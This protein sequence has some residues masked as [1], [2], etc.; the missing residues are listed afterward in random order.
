M[1]GKLLTAT[2]RPSQSIGTLY[3]LPFTVILLR[4]G[5]IISI[6]GSTTATLILGI[7]VVS[8]SSQLTIDPFERYLGIMPGQSVTALAEFDCRYIYTPES[9]KQNRCMISP[10]SNYI[11]SVY[12]ASQEKAII[13]VG[14]GLKSVRVGDLVVLWGRPSR[15]IREARRFIV[16]WNNGATVYIPHKNHDVLNLYWHA[17]S[18][19][20]HMPAS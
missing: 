2:Y 17:M 13:E 15:I 6:I 16:Q 18:V 14:M 1:L 8:N 9:F 12:V 19:L 3:T 10:T 11:E 4:W 20:F 7:G 5:L